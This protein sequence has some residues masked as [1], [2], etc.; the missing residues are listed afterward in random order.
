ML[1]RVDTSI[2]HYG[3]PFFFLHL[4][5]SLF[6]RGPCFMTVVGNVGCF[7]DLLPSLFLLFLHVVHK[8]VISL[9]S[10]V[11]KSIACILLFVVFIHA[12]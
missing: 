7:D 10:T 3:R 11:V 2:L 6:R 4:L 9:Y 1:N 8:F 12:L 5:R